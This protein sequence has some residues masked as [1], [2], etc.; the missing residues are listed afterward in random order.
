MTDFL[1]NVRS[2]WD[3]GGVRTY[4]NEVRNAIRQIEAA[5]SGVRG[6]PPPQANLQ[7]SVQSAQAQA[8]AGLAS[9]EASG[10]ISPQALAGL[11]AGVE[12]DFRRL[13]E[14]L[15]VQ[16]AG[17]EQV[18]AQA[19]RV[20]TASEA[21]STAQER[22]DRL[23]E[24]R[25]ERAYARETAAAVEATRGATAQNLAAARPTGRLVPLSDGSVGEVGGD[26]D[27]RAVRVARA[28]ETAVIR[29]EAAEQ[30]R[31]EFAARLAS[32]EGGLLD[33]RL[34]AKADA[35]RVREAEKELARSIRA[36][37]A[38]GEQ[39][40][41]TAADALVGKR[42]VAGLIAD[43]V[44]RN[45]ADV[46][47]LTEAQVRTR[48]LTDTVRG[49]AVVA[50]G[51]ALDDR[52]PARLAQLRLR[53]EELAS[54]AVQRAQAQAEADRLILSHGQATA[55]L[56][57]QRVAAEA[58]R[59]ATRTPAEQERIE[60]QQ[61]RA[62]E[63]EFRRRER[64]YNERARVEA[65]MIAAQQ[66]AARDAARGGPGGPG[67]PGGVIGSLLGGG[68][69]GG[70]LGGLLGS[71]G[72]AGA[73]GAVGIT[74]YAAVRSIRNM[75]D[76]AQRL[77]VAFA[78][79]QA[80][81]DSL[82]QGD[83]FGN[84]RAGILQIARDSGVAGDQV[85]QIGQ[86]MKAAFGD[87]AT[88]VGLTNQAV[89]VMTVTGLSA[90]EAMNT[91]VAIVKGFGVEG[92]QAIRLV[93][94]EALH[95]QDVFGVGAK[96]L[97][98]GTAN[99]AA[100]SREIG[101][102][103]KDTAT[104]IAAAAEASQR[105]AQQVAS[106]LGRVIPNIQKNLA[107]IVG[108]YNS[109]NLQP[110]LPTIAAD[111]NAG[112]IGDVIKELIRDYNTMTQAQK[113][114]VIAQL[115]GSRSAASLAAVF[116][117]TSRVIKEFD[118]T[119]THEGRT[120]KS[121]AEFHT[122][123]KYAVDQARESFRQLAGIL[124]ESG[125]A[126]IFTDLV[127]A[128]A[129]LFQVL[130]FI[131]SAL[132]K[133]N[134]LAGG[135]PGKVAEITIAVRALSVA[136]AALK[137]EGV[138]SALGRLAGLQGLSGLFGFGKGAVGGGVG[139]VTKAAPGS[140]AWLEEL[141]GLGGAA[142][143]AG[144]AG[145][146]AGL[147]AAAVSLPGVAFAAGLGVIVDKTYQTEKGRVAQSRKAAEDRLKQASDAQLE[148]I[149]KQHRGFTDFVSQHLFGGDTQDLAKKILAD[150][151]ANPP[152]SPV[153]KA[154]ADATDQADTTRADYQAGV[155][156]STQYINSLD[157]EIANLKLIGN[158]DDAKKKLPNLLHERAKVLSDLAR[159]QADTTIGLQELG[160]AG[161]QT[162]V[163]TL[164]SLLQNPNVTDPAV[165]LK[166]AQDIVAGEKQVLAEMVQRQTTAAGQLAVL[167]EGIAIPD[168]ARTELL[169]NEL[170]N[171]GG[172]W[173]TL[174]TSIT[175][176][177]ADA[178]FLARQVA[179]RSIRDGLTNI[180]ALRAEL[181]QEI[182]DMKAKVDQFRHS[183]GGPD[184]V[185]GPV[186]GEGKAQSEAD[187][188][189]AYL[190]AHPAPGEA[191]PVPKR[192]LPDQG[193]LNQATK[194]ADAE[195]KAAADKAHAEAEAAAKARLA[196][197]KAQLEGDPVGQAQ[198][199]IEEA[200]HMADIAT[201]ESERLNAQ[202]Q[203]VTAQNQ[204]AKAQESVGDAYRNIDKA[205]AQAAGDTVRVSQIELDQA[206]E[207]LAN[208]N[209][210]GDKLGALQAQAALVAAQA[211][212]TQSQIDEGTSQTD[213]LL[214]MEQI[215]TGQAIAQLEG[216]LQVPGITQKQTQALLLK[217]HQLRKD[218]SKDLQFDIPSDIKLPTLYEVR[219]LRQSEQA[220]SG[221]QDNRQ[222][223]VQYNVMTPQDH[224]AALDD[225]LAVTNGQPRVGGTPKGY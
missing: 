28:T 118:D 160:G 33:Q 204:L 197:R 112:R 212:A 148:D 215:T 72:G 27:A 30:A 81:F 124:V 191:T 176:S 218:A 140:P 132:A 220:G 24:A 172:D 99:I 16:L 117:D 70:G 110:K 50:E 25:A 206:R 67:G 86:T 60:Q 165:R 84:F 217:I 20:N 36:E 106:E 133:L 201:T 79:A 14:V 7:R 178:A 171:V 48:A 183:G 44:R 135:V 100:L 184:L 141:G 202:A 73:L 146:A 80:Q 13:S 35:L 196:L 161:P 39:S 224:Q 115:G 31:A 61:L 21:A 47:V 134:D 17:A 87:T 77:Q 41:T 101:L 52:D 102:S 223:L 173:N 114:Q 38:L 158:T 82:G 45:P 108:L 144:G 213:F 205:M 55:D 19:G 199:A 156:S 179:T 208:A 32:N 210:R 137:V 131:V 104:I 105:P 6:T 76:E 175:T 56:T 116:G 185:A 216:L 219:R 149:A 85:V 166:A 214:Q 12:R 83:Q 194:A 221:Y 122:T 121:V 139:A 143:A 120:A 66:K 74:G 153:Q 65:Q 157:N 5:A 9:I 92:P 26:A 97:L 68:G 1:I 40:L 155:A 164:T 91:L 71:V 88:A 142:G 78:Q 150:R 29:R 94:D 123:L 209:A 11:R 23:R 128:G 22:A 90:S 162:S 37:A 51:A 180:Q 34:Q 3:V 225:L 62:D 174:F 198:V 188:L 126:G 57:A 75:V 109:P 177:M 46:G 190:K 147:G 8:Q 54:G 49:G 119:S 95:L 193:T 63:A 145:G 127:K 2:T 129:G 89:Q 200:R 195:R 64:A 167:R 103:Y 69:G 186:P 96:E 170:T 154:I 168:A 93:S 189:D 152:Q 10:A 18:R 163:D 187:A 159:A 207:H 15:G 107:N 42:Q 43:Q 130:G 222:T 98:T 182:D 111:I 113:D 59:A 136:F 169:L 192:A 58:R 138:A 211:A 181:Q 4:A 151:K 125:L 53:A 203:L